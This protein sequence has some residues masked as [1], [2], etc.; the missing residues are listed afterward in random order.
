MR[1]HAWA[2]TMTFQ[3]Q[4]A[5]I[6]LDELRKLFEEVKGA[7]PEND[8]QVGALKAEQAASYLGISRR[9]FYY[10]LKDDPDLDQACFIVGV[11]KRWPKAELDAWM[12]R[13]V[14][15]RQPRKKEAA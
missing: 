15:K 9:S 3:N 4:L 5:L 14:A 1:Q 2:R 6:N 11:A 8:V 7:R 10:L 13:Q 12:E